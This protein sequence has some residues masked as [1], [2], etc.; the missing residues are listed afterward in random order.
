MSDLEFR[1][2][3]K[4]FQVTISFIKYMKNSKSD[5]I[6]YD[7][8]NNSPYKVTLPLGLLGYCE[9]NATMFPINDVA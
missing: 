7:V 5:M 6:S 1:P 4:I 2:I 3:Q 8:N 9:T